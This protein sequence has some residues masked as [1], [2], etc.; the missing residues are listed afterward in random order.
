MAGEQHF[1]RR[2]D[3]IERGVREL[4]AVSDP[5]VRVVVQQLVEASLEI[6]ARSLERLLEIVDRSGTSGPSI[7]DQ[8]GRDPLVGPLLV[9]HSLHPC[10][11]EERVRDALE[12]VGPALRSKHATAE[13]SAVTDGRVRVRLLGGPEEKAIVERAILEA[14]PDAAIEIEGA[15]ETVVGFVAV[16]ALRSDAAARRLA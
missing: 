1:Q 4:D 16:D 5:G 12:S 13:L 3:M 10:S 2:L 8:L 11:L 14:A 15:A 7:V 6:H 9:L